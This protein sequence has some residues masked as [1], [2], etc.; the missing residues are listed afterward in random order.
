MK[1]L[2]LFALAL[3]ALAL[4]SC[5]DDN[6]D[7][8]G[9]VPFVNNSLKFNASGYWENTYTPTGDTPIQFGDYL[10]SH[11]GEDGEYP[12]F[13]GFAPSKSENKKKYSTTADWLNN[14]WCSIYGGGIYSSTP[15]LVGSWMEYIDGDTEEIPETPSCNITRADKNTFHPIGIMVCNTSWAYYSMLEGS[16]MYPTAFTESDNCQLTITGVLRGMRTGRVTIDLA[17][18]KDIVS[19]WIPVDLYSLGEVDMI[20]FQMTSTV[21]N[22]YGICNPPT[23]F[24][25]DAFFVE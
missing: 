13:Y 14:Q 6:N 22:N 16:E 24:C 25:I 4:S 20:Y 17:K 2:K 7:N 11:Y 8:S 10:F 1:T 12:Y 18:G 5:S 21:T 15:Y 23:Y 9:A 3:T 19:T